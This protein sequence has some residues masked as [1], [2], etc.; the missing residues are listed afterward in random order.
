MSRI[1]PDSFRSRLL[2]YFA[3]NP[4]EELSYAGVVAKFGISEKSARNI[5]PSLARQGL[6]ES[7]HVIR[8]RSKGVAR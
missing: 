3:R 6:L 2:D 5:V 1:D 8:L 4:D 7:V